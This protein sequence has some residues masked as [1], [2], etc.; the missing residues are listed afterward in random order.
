M[1][2]LVVNFQKQLN[3]V[4]GELLQKF[5]PKSQKVNVRFNIEII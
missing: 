3:M 4:F 2:S 5:L 1:F